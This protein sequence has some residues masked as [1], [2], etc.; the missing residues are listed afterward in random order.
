M[1][2]KSLLVKKQSQPRVFKANLFVAY[3]AE[4]HQFIVFLIG[5]HYTMPA[6]TVE[7][8]AYVSTVNSVIIEFISMKLFMFCNLFLP[9]YLSISATS[10]IQRLDLNI[11][12]YHRK[13]DSVLKKNIILS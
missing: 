1:Q 9:F 3:K 6:L 10:L 12:Y 5:F 7:T 13:E 2:N 11:K 4:N 8:E